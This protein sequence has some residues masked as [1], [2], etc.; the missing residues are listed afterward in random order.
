MSDPDYDTEARRIA[1]IT[2][3]RECSALEA[4]ASEGTISAEELRVRRDALLPAINMLIRLTKC[5]G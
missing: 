4:G 1:R 2:I 5:A 3:A